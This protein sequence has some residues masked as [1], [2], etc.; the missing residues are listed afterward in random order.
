MRTDA[1]TLDAVFEIRA[2]LRLRR[3][4]VQRGFGANE[5]E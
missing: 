2:D 3:M 5:N 1:E 4:R